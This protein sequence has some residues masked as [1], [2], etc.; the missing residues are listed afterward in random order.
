MRMLVAGTSV[1]AIADELHLS[2]KTISTHKARLMQKM[3]LASQA[4]LVRYA[5]SHDLGVDP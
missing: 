1:T 5:M 2:V 3:G 4:D